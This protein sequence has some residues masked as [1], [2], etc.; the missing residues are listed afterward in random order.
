[1]KLSQESLGDKS[2]YAFPNISMQLQAQCD[3]KGISA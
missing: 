1:M 2:L 3:K